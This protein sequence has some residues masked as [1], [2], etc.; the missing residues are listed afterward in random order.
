VT[1]CSIGI[2]TLIVLRLELENKRREKRG[3]K[4]KENGIEREIQ[5]T[6]TREGYN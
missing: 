6:V 2:Q 1:E 4:G 5:G 3:G